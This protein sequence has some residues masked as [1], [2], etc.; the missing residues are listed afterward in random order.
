MKRIKRLRKILIIKWFLFIDVVQ[1]GNYL[2]YSLVTITYPI[3]GS[4]KNGD[5]FLTQVV[6]SITKA[7][8][9]INAKGLR[10]SADSQIFA[11]DD[12]NDTTA[13]DDTIRI[14][15]D[16]QNL[17]GTVATTD[18]TITPTGQS[19]FNPS[20]LTGTVTSGTFSPSLKVGIALAL[21]NPEFEIGDQVSIDIRGRTSSATITTLPLVPSHVR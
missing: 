18:I 15:I 2:S 9:G 5:Q 21:L 16:Q 10:I 12:S 3:T 20:T 19:G 7:V 17:S 6:Q 4:R 1:M 8:A 11:F 13:A 14:Y